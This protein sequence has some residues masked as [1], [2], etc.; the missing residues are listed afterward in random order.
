MI[1]IPIEESTLP[2]IAALNNGVRPKIDLME[3]SSFI[4]Y[5]GD[6]PNEQVPSVIAASILSGGE[7]QVVETRFAYKE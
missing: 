7:F 4:H 3:H 2:L 6:Q 1:I 5:G